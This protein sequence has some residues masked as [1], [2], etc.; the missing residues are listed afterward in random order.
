MTA[1]TFDHELTPRSGPQWR[2]YLLGAGWIRA[3]WMF[4]LFGA[5][6]FGI[7]VGLRWWGGWHPI[8]NM[9]IIALSIFHA[10]ALKSPVP[11]ALSTP[12]P[13][14]EVLPTKLPT[15]SG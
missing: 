15:K 12:S 13:A 14:N 5:I 8:L 2:H 4:C 10:C 9:S 11:S 7:V 1:T 3:I 6:G